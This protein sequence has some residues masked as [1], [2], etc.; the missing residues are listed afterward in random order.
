MKI[1]RRGFVKLGTLTG[2]AMGLGSNWPFSAKVFGQGGGIA[3]AA[4]TAQMVPGACRMCGGDCGIL[5]KVVD[6]RLVK[7]EGNPKNFNTPDGALCIRGNAGTK[8]LYDPDRILYPLK[9][10]GARGE[11]KFKRISWD[12]AKKILADALTKHKE[13]PEK[14][15]L[16][17]VINDGEPHADLLK[18][19]YGTP[20]GVGRGRSI[21]DAPKR[22]ATDLT[23]GWEQHH[24]GYDLKNSKYIILW[25]RSVA[26]GPHYAANAKDVWLAKQNGAKVVVIDPRC[27]PDAGVLADAW[28]PIKPGTDLALALAMLNVVVGEGLYDKDFVEK[29]TVGFDKLVDHVKQYTPEWA[30][31]IT[32]IPAATIREVA[33]G[34]AASKPAYIDIQKGVLFHT[35]GFQACRAMNILMGITGNIDVPGG[36]VIFVGPKYG[37]AAKFPA[38]PKRPGLVDSKKYPVIKGG[39]Y[40]WL[41]Q[42]ILNDK[43]KVLFVNESNPMHSIPEPDKLGQALKS[44]KLELIVVYDTHISETGMYADLVLPDTTCYE[45]WQIM[46]SRAPYPNMHVRSAMVAPLGESKDL[47]E[48]LLEVFRMMGYD[49]PT[50]SMKEWWE[51]RLKKSPDPEIADLSFDKLMAMG[52]VWEKP[53]AMKYRKYA[54]TLKEEQLKDTTVAENGVIKDKNGTAIGIMKDGTAYVGFNTPSRM[55]EVYSSFLAEK[56]IDP[57]PAWTEPEG[58]KLDDPREYPLRFVSYHCI[59][60]S[61]TNFKTFNNPYLAEVRPENY[62]DINA[63]TASKLGIKEGDMVEVVSAVGKVTVKAHL[64]QGMHPDTVAMQHGFGHRTPECK[65]ADGRG[66]SSNDV[67][68]LL[69]DTVGGTIASNETLVKVRKLG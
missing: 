40:G 1:S 45:R 14:L 3:E 2:A 58:Y 48:Y 43:V 24:N 66:A 59:N 64:T 7:I 47:N 69:F 32:G 28:M 29:W 65:V 17:G 19:A 67:S 20:N 63:D 16:A 38:V 26:H 52:G 18:I 41:Y 54:A 46:K 39:M 4:S 33:R 37:D 42:D 44:D 57:L 60:T 6:G 5:G 34:F 51:L 30:E 62:L 9:R 56:G 15:V 25:G 23:F 35:D 61:Q 36:L 8:F 68:R 50:T 22:R 21:C 31:G 27:S 53:G 12:E 49:V 10:V 55:L 13:T 11:G